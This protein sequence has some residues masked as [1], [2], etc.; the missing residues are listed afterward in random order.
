MEFENNDGELATYS[1][2]AGVQLPGTTFDARE[3]SFWATR[4]DAMATEVDGGFFG[5]S[6]KSSANL[7]F[8]SSKA[9]LTSK[10]IEASWTI[11]PGSWKLAGGFYFT[12]SYSASDALH[13][14]DQGYTSGTPSTDASDISA[15]MTLGKNF[16][17]RPT[18]F[19]LTYSYTHVANENTTYPQKSLVYVILVS[20]D[21]KAIALGMLSDNSTVSSATKTVEL[22]YGSDPQGILTA[23]YAGTSDLT[24]GNGSEEVASIR[25]MFA[26]SAYAHV[27]A[28]GAAGNSDK[29]RGGENSEL[30]LDNFKLIY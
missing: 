18:A 26:S 20:K 27:V 14:Y 3:S 12:G 1:V 29:Y 21:K 4:S 2:I 5:I 15:D 25:V 16:T 9:T 13:I 24:L 17:A 11:I 28:G 22:S 6:A 10:L 30:V 7:S 19:E 8:G 23:G